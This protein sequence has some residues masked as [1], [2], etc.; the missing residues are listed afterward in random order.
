MARLVA[1][2]SVTLTWCFEDEAT[3]RTDALLAKLRTDDEAVVP[4]HWPVEVANALLVAI[5]RGRIS[6]EKEARFF[7]D[8][9]ALPIHID[10]KSSE[11]AFG[12]VFA[13]AQQ[14]GLTA[15]DAAYLELAIRESLP[16]ATLDDDL[17]KASRAAG[18]SLVEPLP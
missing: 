10:P 16:L 3:P 11:N 6:R 9:R 15:Y 17:R 18:V 12:R 8:L 4:A 14:Y 7:Q 1:D 5:R 13:L 2:A